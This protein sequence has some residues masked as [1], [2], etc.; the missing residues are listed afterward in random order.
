MLLGC[1]AT[2]VTTAIPTF[3][4]QK[5]SSFTPL[6]TKAKR[7]KQRPF[8][9]IPPQKKINGVEQASRSR[10]DDPRGRDDDSPGERDGFPGGG[11]TSDDPDEEQLYGELNLGFLRYPLPPPLVNPNIID[12]VLDRYGVI[13]STYQGRSTVVNGGGASSI[14]DKVTAIVE[15]AQPAVALWRESPVL[16]HVE[17]GGVTAEAASS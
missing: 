8:H 5:R 3:P 16:Q 17:R 6:S 1:V 14:T 2:A 9:P 15:Q 10:I 12:E 7:P 4:P 11:L 13:S